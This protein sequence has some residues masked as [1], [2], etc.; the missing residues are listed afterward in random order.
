MPASSSC[1]VGTRATAGPP[2]V[3][4]PDATP[5]VGRPWTRLGDSVVKL[6]LHRLV[7]TTDR[8]RP[9]KG[10]LSAGRGHGRALAA[11]TWGRTPAT[12]RLGAVGTAVAQSCSELQYCLGV[13]LAH[14]ALGHAEDLA[15]LGQG[16]AFVVVERQDG[17]LALTQLHDGLAE[18]LFGLLVLEHRHG[19]GG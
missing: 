6:V 3:V 5:R 16:Q 11:T 8:S 12:S 7:K 13:D 2:S 15:D 18:D 19:P 10:G 4:F 1:R 14:T 9:R 17:A